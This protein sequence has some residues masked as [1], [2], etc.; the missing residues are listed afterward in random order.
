[1]PGWLAAEYTTSSRE[2]WWPFRVP[3]CLESTEATL[4][5]YMA[6][7]TSWLLQQTPVQPYR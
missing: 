5:G 3:C 2:H 6:A 4:T 7:E 1:M